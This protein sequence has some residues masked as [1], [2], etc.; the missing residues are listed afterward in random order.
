MKKLYFEEFGKQNKKVIVLLPGLLASVNYWRKIAIEL[1]K[2]NR[3][4][5]ID[6]LGFG[7]SPKPDS[8]VGY[9]VEDNL[10]AYEDLFNSL[11]LKKVGLLVG[12]SSSSIL[13]SEFVIKNPDF[14]SKL[15]LITPPFF[16]SQKEVEKYLLKS[17]PTYRIFMKTSWRFGFIPFVTIFRPILRYFAKYLITH[18]DEA[19]AK[20]AFSFTW[21]SLY[22]SI[23]NILVK[24]KILEKINKIEIPVKILYS[25]KDELQNDLILENLAKENKN[26]ELVEIDATHQI[27]YERPEK[28]IEKIKE[29]N[30]QNFHLS[31][32]AKGQLE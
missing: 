29:F 27:P 20:D 9:T 7:N 15:M 4:I 10:K 28:V 8:L 30:L 6:Q 17:F 18:I 3:V 23:E 11:Q 13:A 25:R 26:F 5:V 12:Y 14:T 22:S 24:Q 31:N 21:K 16:A 32:A 1:Q 19:S 2:N